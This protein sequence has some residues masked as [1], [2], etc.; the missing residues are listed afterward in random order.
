[1]DNEVQEFNPYAPNKK[2]VDKK[3]CEEHQEETQT[4]SKCPKCGAMCKGRFC[5]DCGYDLQFGYS[6]NFGKKSENANNIQSNIKN[7]TKKNICKHCGKTEFTLITKRKWG[8][9]II[10][11][12][13]GLLLSIPSFLNV[14][15]ADY[16]TH[17]T[18]YGINAIAT[19]IFW[20]ALG[21]CI[22]MSRNRMSVIKICN[23]CGKYNCETIL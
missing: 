5:P 22:S 21:I 3:E 11:T 9:F 16:V 15:V 20:S 4:T 13:I 14:F 2:E 19:I 1:M 10:M 23:N 6:Y 8:A 18:A 7:T 17:V 12:L